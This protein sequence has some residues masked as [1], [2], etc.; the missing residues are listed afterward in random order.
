MIAALFIQPD[1]CYS[2]VPGID[3]WPEDR[4]ARTYAGPYSVVAHPPCQRWGKFARV[5]FKRWGG[6]HNRPGNDGGC[7]ASAL[8]SVRTYGG[9]LEHPAQ[10]YA[11][12][13][14]DLPRPSIEWAP[15]WGSP[16]GSAAREARGPASARA[17]RSSVSRPSPWVERT[18]EA[19]TTHR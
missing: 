17:R 6:E 8:R 19:G 10:T 2:E 4:D 5:N 1:G 12:A 18:F 3:L 16:W 7:F 13:E 14:Y 15:I 9:V 11:F